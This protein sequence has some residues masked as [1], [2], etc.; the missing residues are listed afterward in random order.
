MKKINSVLLLFLFMFSGSSWAILDIEI[1]EGVEGGHPIAIVP[2]GFSGEGVAP[3]Q[4]IAAIVSA[5]LKRTGRFALLPESKFLERPQHGGEVNFENWRTLGVESLVVGRIKSLGNGNFSVQF[6]L[7]DIYKKAAG[8]VTNEYKIK[9][10]AGYNLTSNAAELRRTAH[11][12]SDVIYE[13]ITG[14]KGAFSTRIAYVTM[15]VLS[16]KRSYSLQVAD[17]DGYNPFSVLKSPHPIMSP[18]W[19]PD[20]RRLAYVSFENRKSEIYVQEMSTGARTLVSGQKGVNG[21]PAWSPDGSK[22]ALTLSRDGNVEIYILDLQTRA[23]RRLTRSTA[24]DTEPVWSKDGSIIYFVSDRSGNPQIYQVPVTGGQASRLT[25]EGS[26]N[27]RPQ[28]SPDGKHL[29]IVHRSQG[30]YHIA[31]FNLAD[32]TLI[33]LTRGRL[34]ESPSFAPN[35]SMILYATEYQHRGVLS[36]VSIDGKVRQRLILQKSDVREPAWAPFTR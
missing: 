2:F 30:G 16:G 18:S 7:F 8:P 21:A 20:G 32:R 3:G 31:L 28:L 25:F 36:A 4:D 6:Q 1:T 24:I 34:D 23:L 26:Y 5:D 35:G 14:Q 27:A 15:D 11:F 12:I 9:Q 19:S 17:A 22:L 10:L 33:E 13:K 29:A